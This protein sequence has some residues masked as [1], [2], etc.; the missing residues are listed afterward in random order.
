MKD[1]KITLKE[2][3]EMTK[4]EMRKPVSDNTKDDDIDAVRFTW[5]AESE[6]FVVAGYEGVNH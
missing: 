3:H 6:T 1:K 5:D 4:L 2:W